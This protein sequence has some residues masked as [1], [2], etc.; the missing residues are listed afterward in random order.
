ME[1]SKIIF[2]CNGYI[3]KERYEI[4]V[5][6]V[7]NKQADSYFNDYIIRFDN[8]IILEFIHV[9]EKDI[10]NYTILKPIHI[11]YIM[12]II[13]EKSLNESKYNIKIEFINKILWF[14]S[15]NYKRGNRNYRNEYN[16]YLFQKLCKK[17]V[18]NLI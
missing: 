3:Q 8:G 5:R 17:Y 10:D 4:Y 7:Y 15:I 18:N 13:D 9:L 2:N 14:Y 1:H 12:H 16:K 6:G 11:N